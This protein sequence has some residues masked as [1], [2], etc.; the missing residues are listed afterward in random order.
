MKREL[1]INI[2]NKDPINAIT[3]A[4]V[5]LTKKLLSRQENTSKPMSIRCKRCSP[6]NGK[7]N[8]TTKVENTKI[9]LMRTTTL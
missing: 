5:Q 3:K 7:V 8:A 1:T 2:A 4:A 9:V 6:K